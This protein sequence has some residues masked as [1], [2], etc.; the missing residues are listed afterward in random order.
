ML[1][2]TIAALSAAVT[3]VSEEVSTMQQYTPPGDGKKK[4]IYTVRKNEFTRTGRKKDGRT[5]RIG[6][7]RH[8]E[9]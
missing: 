5:N 7:E 8:D 6:G 4:R 1:P 3:P 2:I 9:P